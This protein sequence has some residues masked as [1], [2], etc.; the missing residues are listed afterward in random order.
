MSETPETTTPQEAQA[1]EVQLAPRLLSRW[2]IPTDTAVR[3]TAGLP[4]Y[5]RDQL[6]WLARYGAHGNFSQHEI[7]GMLKKP[8]GEPYS[9]D[10][11]YAALTGRR[12]QEGVS[13]RQMA[14]AIAVFRRR[15]E[16][17]A[18]AR[19][20]GF[21][22][23][24]LSRRIFAICDRARKK[25]RIAAIFGPTQVGKSVI[26]DEYQRTHNHGQTHLV[27]MPTRGSVS[28]FV[29][30]LAS[31]LKIPS[32]RREMAVRRRIFDAF[33][34]SILL[35]VDEAHQCL[36]NRSESSGMTLEIL[37][38]LH[39]RRKCGIVICGT[40]VLRS[41]LRTS[42][43]LNQL[44]QRT[45]PSLIVQ[46]GRSDYTDGELAEF[47]RSFGLEPAP[48]REIGVRYSTGG[49]GEPQS[50]YRQNPW[51]LQNR[52]VRQDSL[53]AWCKLLDDARD[54]AEAS[55]GKMSWS[56]VIVAYALSQAH[57]ASGSE[58]AA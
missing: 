27:R 20:T 23:T 38:E 35:I 3:A 44:W 11:V 56:K 25:G 33:D 6:R 50:T 55:D 8:N 2:G 21:V 48:D 57:A 41:A 36:M 13:L 5:E 17:T 49:D 7:A 24:R 37:R 19:T 58:V 46:V 32:Q 47:S 12:S 31:T 43:V 16:E 40:E 51:A 1:G 14:D 34:P 52:I 9:R 22:E 54:L 18:A 29:E 15:Q 53:G 4:E 26:L 30:E 28:H 42:P 10:S 45:T 39:D